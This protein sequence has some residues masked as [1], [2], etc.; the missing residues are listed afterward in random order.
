MAQTVKNLP[1]MRET[2]FN[3]WRRRWQ[4][5]PV[6]FPGEKRKTWTEEASSS[7]WRHKELDTTERL[8]TSTE[9]LLFIQLA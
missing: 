8:S 3:S 1:E 5:T 7:P 9:I 4:H 6:F 2:G